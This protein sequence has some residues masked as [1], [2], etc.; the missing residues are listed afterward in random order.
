MMATICTVVLYFPISFAAI[1]IPMDD[2]IA[3]SPVMAR[4]LPIITMAIHESTLLNS[5]SMISAAR[6]RSLSATGSI[7]LPKSVTCSHRLAMYPS[8]QSVNDAMIKIRA[9]HCDLPGDWAEN[10]AI[11]IG[12]KVIRKIERILGRFTINSLSLR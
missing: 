3:L 5:T 10:T 8:N 4:S 12:I 7:N 6:T 1:T 2:A 9:A 11:K